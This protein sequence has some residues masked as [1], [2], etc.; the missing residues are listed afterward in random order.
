M[1]IWFITIYMNFGDY[2][3]D[4]TLDLGVDMTLD[5]GVEMTLDLGVEESHL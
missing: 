3:Y 2:L 4:M 1:K 5:L